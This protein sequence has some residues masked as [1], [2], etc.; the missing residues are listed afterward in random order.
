M[1]CGGT[2]GTGGAGGTDGTGGTGEAG[3]GRCCGGNVGS[4]S[5]RAPMAAIGPRSNSL[6]RRARSSLLPPLR[7]VPRESGRAGGGSGGETVGV[8]LSSR[9]LTSVKALLYNA[10]WRR[11]SP[12]LTP[13]SQLTS[14]A[15]HY[16]D[17]RPQGGQQAYPGSRPLRGQSSQTGTVV[18]AARGGRAMGQP[19][20]P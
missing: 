15:G 10:A 20:D 4:Y 5:C 14:A 3:G 7:C 11:R 12:G 13:T 1:C 6:S 2:G 18:P 8:V 16:R 17:A 9:R 19:N